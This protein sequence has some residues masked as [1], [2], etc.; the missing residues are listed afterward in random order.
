MPRGLRVCRPAVVMRRGSMKLHAGFVRV[1]SLDRRCLFYCL[2]IP[3]NGTL[4]ILSGAS[5]QFWHCEPD[6]S[7]TCQFIHP[8]NT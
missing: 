8:T 3:Q 6:D 7:A 5:P 1:K 4:K 2:A